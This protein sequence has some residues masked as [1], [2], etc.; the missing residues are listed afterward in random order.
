MYGS[1]KLQYIQFYAYFLV[2]LSVGH[3]IAYVAHLRFLRDVWIRTQ[4]ACRDK[5]ARYQPERPETDGPCWRLK[6][7]WMETQKVQIK[8]VLPWF[9]FV[10]LVVPVQETFVLPWLLW[11]DQYNKF[12]PPT[13]HYFNLCVPIAQQPGQAVVQGRLSLNVCLCHPF[14][15]YQYAHTYIFLR[16]SVVVVMEH[17]QPKLSS[18]LKNHKQ[19]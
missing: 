6:L 13:V 4:R 2:R 11:S 18:Y 5:Q 7:R 14:D 8:G 17:S 3:T 16:N 15:P 10:G 1:T 19:L 12:F 9:S